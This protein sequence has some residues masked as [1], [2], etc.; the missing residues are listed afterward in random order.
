MTKGF[1]GSDM[2]ILMKETFYK[3]VEEFQSSKYFIQVGV[4]QKNQPI[5][6]V[7]EPGTPNQVMIQKESLTEDTYKKQPI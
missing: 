6:M 7:C 2:S 3:I 4:N 1:S 5:W